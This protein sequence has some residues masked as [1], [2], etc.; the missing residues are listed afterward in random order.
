MTRDELSANWHD[1]I[2][3]SDALEREL[4]DFLA[5]RRRTVNDVGAHFHELVIAA[6]PSSGD[7]TAL[8]AEAQKAGYTSIAQYVA[9]NN[10]FEVAGERWTFARW[11]EM[12][13]DLDAELDA[14]CSVPRLASPDPMSRQIVRP[15]SR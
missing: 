12:G 9:E 14:A 13:A 3:H 4:P 8:L 6:Y 10:Q 15:L 1:Q 2:D 7:G 11:R 5:A